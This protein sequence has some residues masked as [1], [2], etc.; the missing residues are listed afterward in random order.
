MCVSF[1]LCSPRR[2]RASQERKYNSGRRERFVR[3]GQFRTP[4]DRPRPVFCNGLL[5]AWILFLRHEFAHMKSL[6]IRFLRAAAELGWG[7]AILYGLDRLLAAVSKQHLRLFKYYFVAQ[8]VA[9]KSFLPE[10]RGKSV[11]LRWIT[12]HD[13]MLTAP[14]PPH[15]LRQRFEQGAI[16]LVAEIG[17]R[18]SGFLWL[19]L[20]RYREDE[21]RSRY[22]PAPLGRA[23]WDFDVYVEPPQRIGFAFLRMWDEANKFLREHGVRWTLSR[24]SAFNSG[25]MASHSRLGMKRLG[26]AVFFCAWSVELMLA[27]FPP[28]VHVSWSDA[29][30]PDVFL[31]AEAVAARS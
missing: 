30:T 7:N 24:I 3:L 15:I 29:G 20:G 8:P 27:D 26:S 6:H 21:V 5:V 4:V 2:P 11:A 10:S 13:P 22:V 18:F 25:S 14:R 28:Y 31:N 1:G 12:S 9:E 17:G 16:C 19:H 23:A